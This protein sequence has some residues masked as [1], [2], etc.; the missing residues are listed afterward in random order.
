[1][2]GY[3]IIVNGQKSF[4]C[5]ICGNKEFN[6]NFQSAEHNEYVK[7]MV[8]KHICFSC[9]FWLYEYYHQKENA[10][11]ID[12]D[13]IQFGKYVDPKYSLGLTT[14]I[15]AIIYPFKILK[16]SYYEYFGT[17]P[18]HLR[19]IIHNTAVRLSKKEFMQFGQEEWVCKKAGCFDRYNCMRY[20]IQIEADKGPW[21]II[22]KDHQ[23]G[24]EKCPS[25][26]NKSKYLPHD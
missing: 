12:Y 13:Y 10:Y 17:V 9:A 3:P 4:K 24:D 8:E 22:P 7:L 16:C 25:F 2:K 21:N 26:L 15:Y 5:T 19:G 23:I 1:M 14:P 18:T 11:F 20:D 6:F